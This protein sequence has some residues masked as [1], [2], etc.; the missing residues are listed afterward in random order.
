MEKPAKE[1]ACGRGIARRGVARSLQS[2][3]SSS[4]RS[5]QELEEMAGPGTAAAAGGGGI[6]SRPVAKSGV[7][8]TSQKL[9]WYGQIKA[10]SAP[11]SGN[12]V[13]GSNDQMRSSARRSMPSL[14]HSHF[15]DCTRSRNTCLLL[16]HNGGLKLPS[17]SRG[18]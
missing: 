13:I 14:I 17:S 6:S 11:V 7:L 18:H 4:G 2:K 10:G 5:E 3:N 16:L 1:G 12:G 9:G 8:S 15:F